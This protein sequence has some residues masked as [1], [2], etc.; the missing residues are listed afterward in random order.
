[1]NPAQ[2][3]AAEYT[4]IFAPR[5]LKLDDGTV[6][7]VPP[8]PNLRMFD[9]EAQAKLEALEVDIQENYDRG[10][11]I[12]IPYQ[13][14][15]DKAGNKTVL[16]PETRP[17][18]L[19]QPYRKKGKP[20]NPPY[21]VQ[22]VQ[23]ALGEDFEKLRNGTVG[24]KRGSAAHVWRLWNEQGSQLMNRAD[25]DPK[26]EGSAGDLAEDAPPDSQ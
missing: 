20:L 3:Q 7:V 14:I 2:E 8:H 23:I 21:S 11:D 18:E 24:G 26:S 16:Q 13:E 17:G 22:V 12:Q 5:E 15:V 25:V 9:D 10:P 1:M 4:S 6:I 19:K